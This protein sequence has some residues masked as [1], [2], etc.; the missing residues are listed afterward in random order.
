[1]PSLCTL[2]PISPSSIM[3]LD[4]PDPWRQHVIGVRISYVRSIAGHRLSPCMAVGERQRVQAAVSNE[5][6]QYLPFTVR[7]LYVGTQ[8]DTA[9]GR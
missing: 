8:F 2:K 5:N 1:M 3:L 4:D 6:G 7:I 9:I